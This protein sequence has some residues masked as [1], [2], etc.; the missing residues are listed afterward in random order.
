MDSLSEEEPSH[1]IGY[2]DF[3]ESFSS[4]ATV[5]A[6]LKSLGLTS[7]QI[8]SEEPNLAFRAI[9]V[10]L[11]TQP[12]TNS[13]TTPS[14]A[15]LEGQRTDSAVLAISLISTERVAAFWSSCVIK[16]TFIERRSWQVVI[17]NALYEAACFL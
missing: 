4:K 17:P 2:D 12:A 8:Q 13:G 1:R 10:D 7:K 14:Y 6:T 5:H 3:N 9:S 16:K 11:G 15:D